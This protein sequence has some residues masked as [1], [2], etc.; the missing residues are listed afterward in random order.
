M[1]QSHIVHFISG[2]VDA[3]VLLGSLRSVPPFGTDS[4]KI[5]PLGSPFIATYRNIQ[6]K[7]TGRLFTEHA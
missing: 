1:H 6:R 5:E 7:N 2:S 4:V 3:Q